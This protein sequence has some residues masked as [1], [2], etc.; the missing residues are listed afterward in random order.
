MNFKPLTEEELQISSLLPEGVYDYE[1]IKAEDKI[2][3]AGN[4]YTSINLLVWDNEGRTHT[5]FTNMALVFLLKHFCDVNNMQEKYKSGNIPA[6]E[7]MSKSGGKAVIAI[8]G[9]KPN[10]NGGTFKAKNIVKDYIVSPPGSFI[11]PLRE[12]KNNLPFDD[13]IPF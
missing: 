8:E 5:I 7:F 13:A 2:S 10:P 11:K 4:E 1:V 12:E 9:E 6:I 3:K